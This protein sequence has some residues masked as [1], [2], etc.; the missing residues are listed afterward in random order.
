MKSCFAS[1]K[2]TEDCDVVK[3]IYF[4]KNVMSYRK[5]RVQHRCWPLD[6]VGIK[7]PNLLDLRSVLSLSNNIVQYDF[8]MS[9]VEC[10]GVEC[11]HFRSMS[12]M[13][14]LS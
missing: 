3:T 14:V 9:L 4:R 7:P 12:C 10:D 1:R 13:L 8:E 6:F 11:G 2:G 5:R